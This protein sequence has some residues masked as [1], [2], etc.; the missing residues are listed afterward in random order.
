[1][2]TPMRVIK[3]MKTILIADEDVAARTLVGFMFIDIDYRVVTTS[4]GADAISKAREIKPDIVMA[5]VSLSDKDGYEVSR[6][7]KSN[8]LLKDTPV[9]LLTSSLGTFDEIKAARVRADDFIIKPF[10][11]EEITRKVEYL[12]GQREKKEIIFESFPEEASKKESLAEFEEIFDEKIKERKGLEDFTSLEIIPRSLSENLK[13]CYQLMRRIAEDLK[14]SIRKPGQVKILPR[15]PVTVLLSLG[16][17]L[18]ILILIFVYGKEGKIPSSSSSVPAL[19]KTSEETG[20]KVEL[21]RENPEEIEVPVKEENIPSLKQRTRRASKSK[22]R[23]EKELLLQKP[24]INSQSALAML[25]VDTGGRKEL[26]RSSSRGSS[27]PSLTESKK[28]RL[29]EQLR[30]AFL[31]P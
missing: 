21:L 9:I 16:I 31:L 3:S 5:D 28:K 30:R 4:S 24:S 27:R 22:I 17:I 13:N 14:I 15:K 11:F 7:I 1:M 2:A 20:K 12:I 10:K 23:E 18:P 25:P 26:K 29:E 8:P 6:E 19:Y